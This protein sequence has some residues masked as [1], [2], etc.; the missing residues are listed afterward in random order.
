MNSKIEGQQR[1]ARRHFHIS[2][3]DEPSAHVHV[4]S[5]RNLSITIHIFD[6]SAAAIELNSLFSATL[7]TVS[8]DDENAQEESD[9]RRQ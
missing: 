1:S 2:P 7:A 6:A 8:V 5:F 4:G 9:V 3:W